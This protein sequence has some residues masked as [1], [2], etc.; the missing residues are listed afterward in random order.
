MP[1]F[2]LTN[3]F[4]IAMPTLEDPNFARTVTYVCAHNEEGAMGIVINR[5]LDIELGEVLS[6]MQLEARDP[7]IS[8]QQVFQGGPV[9][10]DRGFIIHRPTKDWG[11]TIQ[12]TSE[13]AI[14]TSRE[15]L[16]AISQGTGPTDILVA[17]GYAGWGAGQLEREM[18]QNAW[19]SGP[20]NLDIIFHLPPEHRWARAAADMGID[21]ARLS[22]D[23]GHA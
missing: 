5:P 12:V 13:I 1:T 20:A 22:T 9:H 16:A 8:A 14:S 17:L 19:L 15:I 3:Q 2:D 21:L 4:L 23:V 11:S 18:A 7:A 6:Q 10:R